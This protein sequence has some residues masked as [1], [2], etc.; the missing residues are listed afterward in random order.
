MYGLSALFVAVWSTGFVVGRAI[1]PV[2]SPCLFLTARFLSAAVLFALLAL[3]AGVRWPSWREWPRHLLVGVLLNGAYLAGGYWAVAQGLSPAVMALLG[4]LQ[5]LFTALLAMATLG[6]RP[7]RLFWYGLLAGMVGVGLVLLPALKSAHG[8]I[9]PWVIVVGIMAIISLTIGTV[10]QK[11]S[12]AR[13]DIRASSALQ[14][15]GAALF[16]GMLALAL[17]ESRWLVGPLLYGALAWAALVLSGAGVG[18]LLLLVRRGQVARVATLMYLAPPLAALE[19]FLLFDAR[20]SAVQMVGFVI[21]LLGVLLCHWKET[22]NHAASRAK[23]A[24]S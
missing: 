3:S 13:I 8:T 15:L 17:Q 6:E 18:L 1:V 2:A 19:A 9:S 20:L 11:T 5:P 21:A 7:G 4:A 24:G 16:T 22:P 12:I 10:L 23:M 14:N